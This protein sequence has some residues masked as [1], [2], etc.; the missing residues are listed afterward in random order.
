M[1][2]RFEFEVFCKVRGQGRP[3]FSFKTGRAYEN[4]ADKDYKRAISERFVNSGGFHF[5]NSPLS[6]TIDVYRPLPKSRPKSIDS[7]HDTFAPDCDNI[8]KACLDALNKLAW[9]DDK[10]IVELHVYKH[11]RRRERPECIRIGISELE[12]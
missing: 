1:S 6:V 3:R 4:K 9:N 2:R 8:G 11:I 7:E 12:K 5:G 10:Q